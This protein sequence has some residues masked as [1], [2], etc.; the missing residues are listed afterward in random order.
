MAPQQFSD[1]GKETSD[2][3]SKNFHAGN[4]KLEVSSKTVEGINLLI[5]GCQNSS[6]KLSSSVEAKMS[7]KCGD[8][9]KTWD[10]GDKIDIEYVKTVSGVKL[11]GTSAFTTS[12]GISPGNLKA[13]WTN[14]QLNV[15]LKSSLSAAPMVNFDAVFAKD[16]FSVGAAL[17]FCVQSSALKS[18]QVALNY[19]QGSL[20]STVKSALDGDVTVLCS[21]SHA[22]GI[23]GVQASYGKSTNFALAGTCKCGGLTRHFKLDHAGILDL[24]ATTS[25][26][27]GMDLTLSSQLNLTNMQSGGHKLGAQLK[28]NL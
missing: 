24:S 26:D 20:T 6:G 25:L 21:N 28:F 14:D 22:K 2:L 7:S 18:K 13:N 5:K 16:K 10:T 11:T 23:F 15:N 17:G 1:L 19:K 9:K 12:G 3:F 27:G 8:F 4:V